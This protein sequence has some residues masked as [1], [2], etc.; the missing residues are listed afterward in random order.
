MKRLW[1]AIIFL[2]IAII[3]CSYEQVVIRLGYK[4]IVSV[5]DKAVVSK[6]QGEKIEYCNDVSN[7]WDEYHKKIAL[8]TDHSNFQ[9]ADIY[10]SQLKNYASE[11]ADGS[12]DDLDE[13]LLE[14]KS[15][16]EQTYNSSKI[17]LSNVF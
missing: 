5:I 2:A 17:N 12:C 8:V 10:I 7:L 16:L 11:G 9:E 15:Q 4:E 6:N 14:A 13:T 3:S 1:F